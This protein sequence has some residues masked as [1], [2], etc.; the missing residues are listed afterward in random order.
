MYS[1]RADRLAA[2]HRVVLHP[3]IAVVVDE[4]LELDLELLA[5]AEQVDVVPGMR[6]GPQLKYRSGSSS[7]LQTCG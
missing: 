5:V 2:E 4:G 3:G 7:K 1:A 6:A